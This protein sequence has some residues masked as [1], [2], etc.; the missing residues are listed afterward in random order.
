MVKV[1]KIL[2]IVTWCVWPSIFVVPFLPVSVSLLV[3]AL[4]GLF[5]LAIYFY[6]DKVLL[7]FLGA[8][9][10]RYIYMDELYQYIEYITFKHGIP[11][12]KVYFYHGEIKKFFIV[13]EKKSWIF[14]CEKE[15]YEVIKRGDYKS[16]INELVKS[17][18][19]EE[20][21]V[22][23]KAIGALTF[24]QILSWETA[25]KLFLLK[26]DSNVFLCLIAAV[27]FLSLPMVYF[28]KILFATK[29]DLNLPEEVYYRVKKEDDAFSFKSYLLAHL[30]KSNSIE[31]QFKRFL[32]DTIEFRKVEQ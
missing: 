6:L 13:K 10:S 14:V 19:K 28:Y 7:W 5:Q 27:N 11:R 3:L 15:L 30:S 23:L 4:I 32:L 12:P 24:L 25:E 31:R 18:T 1:K 9:E 21:Q 2:F 29:L 16:F 20:F 26:K 22:P 17:Y 8:R